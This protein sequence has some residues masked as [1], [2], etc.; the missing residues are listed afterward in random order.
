ML[1]KQ[2]NLTTNPLTLSEGLN[3]QVKDV[4]VPLGLVERIRQSKQKDN[5]SLKQNISK[6]NFSPEQGSELYK[7]TENTKTFEHDEFLEEVLRQKQSP[8]SQGKRIAIIGE[9]GA[10]KTT[11]LQ[12]IADWILSEIKQAIVVWVS[13]ADLQGQTLEEYLYG[14]W[15]T[16][17]ERKTGKGSAMGQREDDFAT[18][19]KQ[20]QIWLLLDGLDEMSV[21]SSNPMTEIARQIREGGSISQARIILTCRVNLCLSATATSK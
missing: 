15:L 14:T 11:L 8:K 12:H 13:L 21:S 9:P 6:D 16:A 3:L 20:G 1:T 4:Y 7:E 2:Q 10:G 19:F 17:I 5:V 18:Q